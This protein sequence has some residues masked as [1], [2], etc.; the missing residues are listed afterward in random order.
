MPPLQ[1]PIESCSASPPSSPPTISHQLNSS[2]QVHDGLRL[3][4]VNLSIRTAFIPILED[5]FVEDDCGELPAPPHLGTRPHPEPPVSPFCLPAQ[6][7]EFDA[8][9]YQS[10]SFDLMVNL[11]PV[12]RISVMGRG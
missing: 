9:D 5:C 4:T 6:S 10:Y 8:D 7:F 11:T 12:K 2:S 1:V 3:E